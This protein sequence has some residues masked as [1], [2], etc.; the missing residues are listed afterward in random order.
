MVRMVWKYCSY[1]KSSGGSPAVS[2]SLLPVQ[3]KGRPG[4]LACG[5]M[6]NRIM[7]RNKAAMY[8]PVWEHHDPTASGVEVGK[9]VQLR[10]LTHDITHEIIATHDINA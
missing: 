3:I 5:L 1:P 6:Y 8:T 2:W 7:Q 10:R 4:L 9:T